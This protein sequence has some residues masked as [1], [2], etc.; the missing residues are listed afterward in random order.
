MYQRTHQAE[1]PDNSRQREIASRSMQR[2]AGTGA[3]QAPTPGF[4]GWE[5]D[6]R[7]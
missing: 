1:K 6:Y 3:P 4:R 7:I 5:K 2:S